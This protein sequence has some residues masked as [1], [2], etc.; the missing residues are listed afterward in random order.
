MTAKLLTKN[1]ASPV[2]LDENNKNNSTI[3]NR[4]YVTF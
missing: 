4:S 3:N 2:Q 1:I